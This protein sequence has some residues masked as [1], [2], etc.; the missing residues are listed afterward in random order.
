MTIDRDVDATNN[1][2]VQAHMSQP[3]DVLPWDRLPDEA[4]QHYAWFLVYLNLGA[5]RNVNRACAAWLRGDANATKGDDSRRVRASSSWYDVARANEWDK[6]ATEWDKYNLRH[7]DQVV[8]DRVTEWRLQAVGDVERVWGDVVVE[9]EGQG[10]EDMTGKQ[11][12]DSLSSISRIVERIAP[13]SPDVSVSIVLDRLPP[14]LQ[15]LLA[16]S[17]RGS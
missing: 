15:A 7:A 8:R 16:D 14:E 6:R 2:Q 13:Q 9:I 17:L 3:L 4:Q 11:L 10:L 5:N 12:V 1:L